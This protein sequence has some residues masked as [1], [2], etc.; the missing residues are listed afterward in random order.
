MNEKTISDEVLYDG[1]LI[2]LH[3]MEVEL[4]N[5]HR[6]IREIV[7]FPEV[8]VV[9]ACDVETSKLVLVRQFRKPHDRYFIEPVAGKVDAGETPEEAARREFMEETGFTLLELDKMGVVAPTVGYSTELQHYFLGVIE[10]KAPVA[11]TGDDD[12]NIEIVRWSYEELM[13][14][15]KSGEIVDGKLMTAMGYAMTLGQEER[16]VPG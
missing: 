9:L 10:D 1:R 3:K 7:K 13:E 2:K 11:H 5:G 8:V 14:H 16:L 4:E 12:E 6:S 15:F